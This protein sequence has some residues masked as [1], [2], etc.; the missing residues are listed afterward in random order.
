W[1]A[2]LVI[3]TGIYAWATVAFGPRF[4][5][6]TNRGIMTHG[7][8]A[9]SRH[10]AYLAKNMFWWMASVPVLTTG[11]PVDAVRATLILAAVSGVYYWR[12]KTEERHLRLDP[13]YVTYD[14]WMARNGM[15]PRAF[16]RWGC[17]KR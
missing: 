17:A 10:P 4:S 13:D 3:L 5:N 15:V 8:Y 1:G 16:Q 6:L 9:F 2:A 7:P 14:A 12:A 11:T